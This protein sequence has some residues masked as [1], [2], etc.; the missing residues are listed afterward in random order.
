M[1]ALAI[2]QRNENTALSSI[3]ESKPCKPCLGSRALIITAIVL[4]ILSAAAITLGLFLTIS[5]PLM[6][7]VAASKY[8]NPVFIMGLLSIASG[9]IGIHASVTL[10]KRANIIEK[11]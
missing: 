6:I 11:E 5:S 1:S 7:P 10:F 2:T 8:L 4:G 9:G 3:N